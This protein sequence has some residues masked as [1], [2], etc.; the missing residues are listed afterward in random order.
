MDVSARAGAE[1]AHAR[2]RLRR[3][4]TSTCDG[5]TDLYVTSAGYNVATDSW[6]ALLWNNGD[7]TFTEGAVQAGIDASM[8]WHSAAAVGDVNGDGRP[9]L[10]VSSATPIRTSSVD[11]GVRLPV[12]PP[13]GPRPPLPQRRPRRDTGTRRS[14]RSRRRP[15]IERHARRARPRRRVHGRRPAT[16]ASTSTSR[17]TLDPNQLYV[18]VPSG[19]S[20]LGFR[21]EDEARNGSA[22]PTRTRA[23]GSLPQDYSGD[24]RADL[25]VTN[26]RDQLH[27]AYRSRRA[28]GSSFADARPDVRSRGRHATR[29]R[30]ACRGPTIWTA[31]LGTLRTGESARH[32]GCEPREGYA[33]GRVEILENVEVRERR[34]V[35]AGRKNSGPRPGRLTAGTGRGSR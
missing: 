2:R 35:R 29:R 31:I 5:R 7:G 25:F 32:P 26:S 12:G 24:G 34:R 16:G 14:G 17:T 20:A 6:D 21:F 3:R 22:S 15:G 4:P 28:T 8:G 10:F 23:W 1:P 11:S 33:R 18:N 13:G 27:A 30:G 19:R 9:D